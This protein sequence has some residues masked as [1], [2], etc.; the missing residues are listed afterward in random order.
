MTTYPYDSKALCPECDGPTEWD[1]SVRDH[2]DPS[3]PVGHGQTVAPARFCKAI[4]CTYHRRPIDTDTS[5]DSP[6]D[7]L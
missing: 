5:D 4:D 2:H 7:R 1:E 6:H 3:S